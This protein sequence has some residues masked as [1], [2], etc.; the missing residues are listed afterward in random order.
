MHSCTHIYTH[1]RPCAH[2]RSR[3]LTNTR[4][5]T[6]THTH[7]RTHARK[8]ARDTISLIIMRN[9][10]T[11]ERGRETDRNTFWSLSP[12]IGSAFLSPSSIRSSICMST[13]TSW[14]RA[15]STRTAGIS[16]QLATMTLIY[17]LMT[18]STSSSTPLPTLLPITTVTVLT[19]GS[20]N[21]AYVM[22]VFS[23]NT[24]FIIIIS[25]SSSSSSSSIIIF[26]FFFFFFFFLLLLFAFV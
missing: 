6:H 2:T 13:R 17:G 24:V 26:F 11:R 3:T 10:K 19:T 1:V 9:K 5:R 25:S 23:V 8:H 14:S 4:A 22:S 12:I 16:P 18:D 15:I 7:T 21:Y 20:W